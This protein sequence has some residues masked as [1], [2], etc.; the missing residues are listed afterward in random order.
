[1]AE[2][3]GRRCDRQDCDTFLADC[4]PNPPAGWARVH[5][6]AD[7]DGKGNSDQSLIE[8]CSDFC[9]ATW[10]IERYMT[11]TGKRYIKPMSKET[12]AKMSESTK[13][14]KSAA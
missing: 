13:N 14:R 2:V 3:R 12:R 8:F 10:F 11:D 5:I 6:V 7:A 1:M 9:A 4:G